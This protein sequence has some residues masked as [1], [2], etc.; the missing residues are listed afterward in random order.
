MIKT[1]SD[2]SNGKD[3]KNRLFQLPILSLSLR[4]LLL[5]LPI[6]FLPP[7]TF[8]LA[9]FSFAL[10]HLFLSFQV[11]LLSPFFLFSLANPSLRFLSLPSPFSCS[12]S[13]LPSH[14]L[15]F[16]IPSSL[17]T[18]QFSQSFL[19]LIHQSI[20][21][22]FLLYLLSSSSS[23][24]LLLSTTFSSFVIPNSSL[25]VITPFFSPSFFCPSL[26][27]SFLLF[28]IFFLY[29]A[30]SPLFSF[31][32]SFLFPHLSSLTSLPHRPSS[33]SPI[34]RL[35]TTKARSLQREKR[36]KESYRN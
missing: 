1:G 13:L 27:P 26:S 4:S 22:L 29:F 5:F 18:F 36:Q 9:Y 25:F 7:S 11:L 8:S 12:F 28:S 6:F 24:N 16:V 23:S 19:I 20:A 35:S 34:L 17:V 21:F 10:L 14:Y 32:I 33:H 30:T 2:N 15:C 31:I 3:N